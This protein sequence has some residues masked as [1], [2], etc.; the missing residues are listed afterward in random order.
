MKLRDK[1]YAITVG[2]K[3][4]DIVKNIQENPTPID[5][6]KFNTLKDKVA[7]EI[8]TDDRP[9]EIYIGFF[10]NKALDD[11]LKKA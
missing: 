5:Y 4:A 10:G 8:F 9:E 7:R 6:L 3:I 1:I 2:A 11:Y